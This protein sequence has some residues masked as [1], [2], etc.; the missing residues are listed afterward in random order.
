MIKFSQI[1]KYLL[2]CT[3]ICSTFILICFSLVEF[4]SNKKIHTDTEKLPTNHTGLVLGTSQYLKGGKLN[5]YFKN[6]ITAAVTLFK[7]GKIKY[8]LVSGDN[9]ISNYNEPERMRRELIKEGVPNEKIILDYAGFRTLDS[10]V[11]SNKVFGQNSITIISQKFHNKRALYIANHYNIEAIAFN[12][13]G[14]SLKKGLKTSA[15]EVLARVKMVLDLY[16]LQKEP[17]FLGDPITIPE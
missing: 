2:L 15:R 14:I 16:L 9:R 7:K 5:P 4:S 11:R 8:I 10:V 6:R 17:H 12:A 1:R 13:K 3:I